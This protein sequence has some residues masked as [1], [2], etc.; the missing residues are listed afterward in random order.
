MVKRG[1]LGQR[2]F[3]CFY[4]NLDG[5]LEWYECSLW[6]AQ[7]NTEGVYV[8][9]LSA[10]ETCNTRIV[11]VGQG[12]L[13]RRIKSHQKPKSDVTGAVP[14]RV[15]QYRL[16]VSWAIVKTEKTRKGVERYL[17]EEL[18]PEEGKQWH[19]TIPIRVELPKFRQL[20]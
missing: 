2:R 18:L 14:C 20:W 13:R 9:Y 1:D 19:N 15:N 10:T 16:C 8:I 3:D 6:L 7:P 17:A 12:H 11:Y 5:S 4:D